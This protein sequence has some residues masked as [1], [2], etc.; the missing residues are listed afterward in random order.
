[1]IPDVENEVLSFFTRDDLD[2]LQ[3][4]SKH[5]AASVPRTNGLAVRKLEI[6]DVVGVFLTAVVFI[7]NK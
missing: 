7:T 1:M 3:L 5:F 4:A 2:S 6:V